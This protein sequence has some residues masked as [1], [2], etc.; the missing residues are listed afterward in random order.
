MHPLSVAQVEKSTSQDSRV[1]EV[2]SCVAVQGP[3]NA[4]T[5]RLAC[6]RSSGV[7]LGYRY[8]TSTGYLASFPRDLS[9][10]L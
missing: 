5:D 2:G 10:F 4:S 9:L 8:R 6:L 1:L 7:G 3:P